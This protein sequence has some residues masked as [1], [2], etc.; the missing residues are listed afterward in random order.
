MDRVDIE[1]K[2]STDEAGL[3]SGYASVFG[4]EPDS[5]GD[6][7]VRGAFAASLAEHKTAG[8]APLLLWQH[9]PSEPI[10]VWLELREDATGLAVSGRLILETR[11][12]Q[13]AYALLK[14]GALNG[15]SIGF[16]TRD[17][18]RRAGG[19]RNLKNLEL[20]EISLVSIP[21]ATRARVTSVKTAQADTSAAMGAAIRRSLV[22]AV[23]TKTPAPDAGMDGDNAE[24]RVA[25]L[26]ENVSGIDARLKSVE[27]SVGN[28]AKSAERIEQKLNR[29]GAIDGR[30]EPGKV[31]A[32]AFGAFVRLGV[33]K[34]AADEVKTL[35]AADGSAGGYLA[36]AEFVRELD[37]N[38]VLYS[39]VRQ[40]ARVS[41]TSSGSVILPKRTGTLTGGWVG[42]IEERPE[43]EPSYGEHELTVHE[44]AVSVPVSNQLLEDSAFNLDAELAADFAEEFGRIEASAFVAGNGVKKP[45]GF[46][47]TPDIP[48][49][50]SGDAAGFGEKPIHQ[51]MDIFHTVPTFYAA[52]AVWGMNRTTMGLLRQQSDAAGYPFWSHLWGLDAAF[53]ETLFGRPVIEMP[54]LP[55]VGANACPIVFGNFRFFR[56]FDRVSLSV[57]RDPYSQA[58]FGKTVFH[59]RRR[60][61]AGVTKAD[62]FALLKIAA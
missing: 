47:N 9:D 52:D 44:I 49:V 35:R 11:R 1:V 5:Y 17:S 18:E 2:F 10:G 4:G 50:K 39:P 58:K 14:A 26:E 34:M 55:D 27:D 40:A 16:R 41:N 59:A 32:K 19:G 8:T 20:I 31:E 56:I 60:L 30:A 45:L 57:L 6:V 15:L 61:A 43:S 54:D 42:E 37:K 12:G 48:V 29:P 24:V 51:L 21:A 7:I 53:S 23:E 28:V 46:L 13:E 36:P 33:E 3:L 22:V 62:A 38:L 25:A